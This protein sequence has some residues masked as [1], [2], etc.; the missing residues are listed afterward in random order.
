VA[1]PSR[2][3]PELDGRHQVS[4]LMTRPQVQLRINSIA[5]YLI[6]GNITNWVER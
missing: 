4:R 2:V 3:D 6:T 1:W 5:G